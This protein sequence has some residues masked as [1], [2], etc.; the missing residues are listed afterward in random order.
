MCYWWAFYSAWGLITQCKFDKLWLGIKA[1]GEISQE[2]QVWE[3]RLLRF[4]VGNKTVVKNKFRMIRKVYKSWS[5]SNYEWS[6]FW[7]VAPDKFSY[8]YKT[9]YFRSL[10]VQIP[11]KSLRGGFLQTKWDIL[12]GPWR[13][14]ILHQANLIIFRILKWSN[15]SRLALLW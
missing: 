8:T 3:H 7:I 10:H 6:I 15:R 1:W 12:S 11:V 4:W 2:P 14:V 9:S 13:K 5:T